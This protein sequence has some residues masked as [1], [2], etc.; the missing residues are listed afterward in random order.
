MD[1]ITVHNIMVLLK[2]RRRVT[3]NPSMRMF[4]T[5]CP[6]RDMRVLLEVYFWNSFSTSWAYRWLALG[7]K[8]SADMKENTV[9]IQT[10]QF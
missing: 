3:V 9:I 7:N 8:S 10:N 4:L 1:V 6:P 5:Y 2:D